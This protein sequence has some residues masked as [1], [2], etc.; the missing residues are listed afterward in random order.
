MARIA[1]SQWEP[2]FV[3]LVL[4]PENKKEEVEEEEI[5]RERNRRGKRRGTEWRGRVGF[6]DTEAIVREQNLGEVK[7]IGK[8]AICKWKG[9]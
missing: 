7:W 6:R 3:F 5:T 9:K 4:P 2:S 1:A 8:A